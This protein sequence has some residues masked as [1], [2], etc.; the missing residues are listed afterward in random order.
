M[1]HVIINIADDMIYYFISMPLIAAFENINTAT[2]RP[3]F[4]ALI[5]R[6]LPAL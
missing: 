6:C 5:F 4:L 3:P 2:Q 1:K